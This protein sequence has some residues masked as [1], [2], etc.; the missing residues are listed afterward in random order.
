MIENKLRAIHRD[1]GYLYVGLIVSFAFSG[2]LMNHRQAWH[3]EKYTIETKRIEIQRFQEYEFVITDEFVDN[4]VDELMIEDKLK[5]H[6][7]RNG[8]LRM[9]FDNTE[10]EIDTKTGQGE[11]IHFIKTPLISHLIKLHK[12]TSVFWIYYSDIFGLS[13]IT[14]AITGT[15]L[16]TRGKYTFRKRG[17]KLALA[18]IL[19]PIIF[20]ALLS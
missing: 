18:G 1:L 16:F 20:L 19:F 5:R 17:W 12:N 7:V 6:L 9:M 4:L 8:Q 10:V 3:P 13:L 15:M 2:I 11:I 14:I